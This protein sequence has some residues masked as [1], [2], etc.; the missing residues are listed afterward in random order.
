MG[1]VMRVGMNRKLYFKILYWKKIVAI[2]VVSATAA[3]ILSSFFVRVYKPYITTSAIGRAD[4]IIQKI[5]NE[6]I[7]EI[8]KRENCNDLAVI[9]RDS[10]KK[11]TGIEINTVKVN[12]M[13]SRIINDITHKLDI[14][15]NEKFSVP[16]F[17]FLNNPL[18]SE[19]GPVIYINIRPIGT[20]KAD[21]NSTFV[22]VGVNQTKHQIDLTCNAE[23]MI[24]MPTIEIKHKVSATVPVTQTVIVGEV[25]QTYTNIATSKENLEDVVL[26]LAGN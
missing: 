4:H 17:V 25:P 6:T 22:S 7:L 12:I 1:D 14:V 5:L 3:V 10:E 24:V 9:I 18:L 23:L 8:L 11:I 2:I 19:K 20:I 21:L 16:L 13:K 15:K 26:Q